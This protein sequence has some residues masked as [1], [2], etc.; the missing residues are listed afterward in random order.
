MQE[1]LRSSVVTNELQ[2]QDLSIR[3]SKASI[4]HPP[5]KYEIRRG[6]Q[7]VVEEYTHASLSPTVRKSE[8]Q[9]KKR[10]GATSAF[11]VDARSAGTEKDAKRVISTPS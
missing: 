7:P 5:A 6:T 1:Q 11:S 10:A 3:G 9:N 8:D 4:S 2:N